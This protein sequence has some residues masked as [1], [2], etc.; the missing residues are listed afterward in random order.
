MQTIIDDSFLRPNLIIIPTLTFRMHSY[1]S[2]NRGIVIIKK[3]SFVFI[4]KNS[5]YLEN[6]LNSG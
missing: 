2:D 1:E 4:V 6:G 5:I 3:Y